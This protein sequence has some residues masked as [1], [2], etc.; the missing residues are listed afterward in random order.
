MHVAVRP[1]STVVAVMVAVPAAT[2]VTTPLASTVAMDESLVVQVSVLFVAFDGDTVAVTV[3][4][5][6]MFT[7]L[8]VGVT[9]IDVTATVEAGVTVTVTVAVTATPSLVVAVAVIVTAPVALPVTVAVDESEPAATLAIGSL[10]VHVHVN[11]VSSV[12]NTAA[13]NVVLPPTVTDDDAAVIL[14]P[15]TNTVVLPLMPEPSLA[16]AMT[17][18]VPGV[19]PVKTPELEIVAVPVSL[20]A[21]TD[22]VT[23]GSVASNGVTDALA[24][25]VPPTATLGAATDTVIAVTSTVGVDESVTVTRQVAVTCGSSTLVAVIVTGVALGFNAVT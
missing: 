4:V 23:D 8:A 25:V 14:A 6:L 12:G 1:P 21:P 2:P 18:T 13:V 10:D 19:A 24:V 22:H 15:C 5:S 9:V 7:V 3:K 17:V 16:V 11:P 20:E